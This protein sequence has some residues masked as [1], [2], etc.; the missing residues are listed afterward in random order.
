ME[1]Y[2]LLV[3]IMSVAFIISVVVW[4]IVGIFLI[5]VLKKV[6]AA[7]ITAHQA[8][9]NVQAMTAQFKNATKITTVASI[10]RQAVKIFKGG[11]KR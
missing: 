9:E 2:D 8:V 10:A 4:I 11:K 5:Q 7:S 6:K 3:I 1:S